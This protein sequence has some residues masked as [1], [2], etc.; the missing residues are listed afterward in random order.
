MSQASLMHSLAGAPDLTFDS[1]AELS[2]SLALDT[3]L[4]ST[5][6][7]ESVRKAKSMHMLEGSPGFGPLSEMLFNPPSLG[8]TA[9]LQR[10][11]RTKAFSVSSLS[12][13]HSDEDA[14][15]L[16]RKRH[17]IYGDSEWQ[18]DLPSTNSRSSSLVSVVDEFSPAKR[19]S[20][21]T[22]PRS[23]TFKTSGLDSLKGAIP[24][25]QGL[26]IWGANTAVEHSLAKTRVKAIPLPL[27]PSSAHPTI[28]PLNVK[29]SSRTLSIHKRDTRKGTSTSKYHPIVIELMLDLDIAIQEWQATTFL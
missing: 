3:P 28:L 13:S 25:R 8:R 12:T 9:I 5:P 27:L 18:V 11:N 24:T 21:V 23:S 16:N 19:P 6:S 14:R 15:T 22:P 10:R 4:T 29:S 17:A 1:S 26:G 7:S 20:Y 2:G